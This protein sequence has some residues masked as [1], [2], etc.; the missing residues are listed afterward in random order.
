MLKK[1]LLPTITNWL[2]FTA[3]TLLLFVNKVAAQECEISSDISMPVCKGEWIKLSVP[4]NA[5]YTYSWLPGGETTSEILIKAIET[6][7]FQVT[8]INR[9]TLEECVSMP[10]LVEVRPTFSIGFEQIQLTC[11]NGDNDNGNNAMLQATASGEG[12]PF[13]YRWD[14]RPIQIA[15]GNPSMAIGL[16]AHLWYFVEIEN[17]VGCVQRDSM[18]TLAYT[19]PI[20]EI[21]ADPDTAYIQN[22]FI[23]FTFE[24]LSADSIEV[25]NYFWDFGDESP[26]SDLLTPNHLYSEE[27]TYNVYLTIDNP[28]GCDTMF[29]KEVKV[30]PVKLKIPNVITPNG[31]GINDYFIITEDAGT[32]DIP[33]TL[34]VAEYENYKPLSTY[35]KKTTLVIFNRQ[36]RKLLESG[37]YKNDWDGGNL[38]DGVYFY[39]LQCEGFKSNEVYRGSVTIFGKTN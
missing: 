33:E 32:T 21:N 31:D 13:L 27:G 4:E 38:K 28:Q 26:T 7:Q 25:T 22:P 19:N 29:T 15:P 34:K 12:S 1:P 3:F 18:Y 37:D 30:L 39:V 23:N 8:V 2:V 16:K 17:S 35:Y 9:I 20:V 5:D 24:N 6:K 11:S 36:G 10:F 14:V